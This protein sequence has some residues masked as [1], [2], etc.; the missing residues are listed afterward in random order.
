MPYLT[1]SDCA[2]EL[3]RTPA[4]IRNYIGRSLLRPKGQEGK[5][6]IIDPCEWERFKRVDL[7]K[8]RTGRPPAGA[9]RPKPKRQ[10][11]Q[12]TVR[13]QIELEMLMSRLKRLMR[14]R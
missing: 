1:V 5:S 11:R 12:M 13:E 7:P 3:G 10:L 2:D 6:L 9:P 8:I 14:S 4:C